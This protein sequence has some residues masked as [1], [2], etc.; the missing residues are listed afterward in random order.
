MRTVFESIARLGLPAPA[1]VI[2]VGASSGQEIDLFRSQGIVRGIFIEPLSAPF[3]LLMQRISGTPGYLGVNAICG[4]VDG[5]VVDFHVAT[6]FGESSSLL[7]PARHLADYPMVQFPQV[8]HMTAFTLD[9]IVQATRAHHP[10]RIGDYELLFMDVQGAEREVLKGANATLHHVR[11]FFT[12]VGLGGGYAGD[13]TL[14]ELM[15]FLKP[16]GFDPYEIEI[17]A[18]GWGNALFVKRLP[19]R[20]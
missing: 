3:Q 2:Q 16:W 17:G 10:E 8:A 14:L 1:G 7:A 18:E 20:N 6:N 4:P 12:E 19:G 15:Q 13:V 9:R 11:Y 5:A